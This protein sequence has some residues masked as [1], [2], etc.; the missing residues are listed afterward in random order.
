MRIAMSAAA[1]AVLTTIASPA[2]AAPRLKGTYTLAG[3]QMCQAPLGRTGGD[4]EHQMGTATFAPTTATAATMKL[5][6]KDQ[7]GSSIANS[8]SVTVSTITVDGTATITGTA[9][10]YVIALS[11]KVG[12]Q[13]IT[14][15][16]F[17]HLDLDGALDGIA[18]RA[19]VQTSSR[20]GEMAGINCT[21]Q[22][23]L[24]R[25]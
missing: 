20:N 21:T 3:T 19:V 23:L 25:Q 18:R 15:S 4:I 6:L 16:G 10:P 17:V 14:T 1:V 11:M 22:M 9:N 2:F 7:W 5:V 12:G 24:F 8:G 13:T